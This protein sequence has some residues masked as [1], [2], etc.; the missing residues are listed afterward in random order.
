M[1]DLCHAAAACACAHPKTSKAGI[2]HSLCA[3]RC[4]DVQH[5]SSAA[6]RQVLQGCTVSTLHL[7]DSQLRRA[8]AASRC[9]PWRIMQDACTY[10]QSCLPDH[11]HLRS[12]EH[13]VSIRVRCNLQTKA[14]QHAGPLACQRTSETLEGLSTGHGKRRNVRPF[15]IKPKQWPGSSTILGCECRVPYPTVP[16]LCPGMYPAAAVLSSIPCLAAL[17]QRLALRLPRGPAWQALKG[18]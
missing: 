3:V 18:V 7:P 16:V 15:A 14:L 9:R 5:L 10:F 13:I 17:P 1:L 11:A 4:T 2:R 6:T 8:P 12:L